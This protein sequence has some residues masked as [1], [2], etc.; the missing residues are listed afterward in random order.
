VELTDDD[1]LAG[2]SAHQPS[3]V[4]IRAL[5]RIVQECLTNARKHAPG[6]PVRLTLAGGP[7]QGIRVTVR[8]G[9]TAAPVS[10]AAPGFGLIGLRERVELLG[11][12]LD[13]DCSGGRFTVEAE[14]PWLK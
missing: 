14:L 11:G 8:N 6:Q 5:Y 1:G 2:G 7:A 13:V 9:L 3:D 12:R 10:E 4:T